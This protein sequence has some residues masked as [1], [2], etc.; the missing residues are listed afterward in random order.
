MAN[1][2]KITRA[3]KTAQA[4]VYPIRHGRQWV[5]TMPWK[6]IDGPTTHS[7]PRDYRGALLRSASTRAELALELLGYDFETQCRASQDVYAGMDWKLAVR[8]YHSR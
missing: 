2:M 1:I 6:D 5:V 4:H 3:L 8:K 7:Q